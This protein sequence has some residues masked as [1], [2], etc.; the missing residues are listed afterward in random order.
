M[1]IAVNTRALLPGKMEGYGYYI[2]EVF[3]RIAQLH[4]EHEFYFFFD[5][6]FA[7]QFVYAQN[8]KPVVI[9]PQ[10]RLPF[11]WKIWYNLQVPAVLKKINADVFVSPD[12]F[13]S[14]RTN[15]PQCL[16]VHD[17]AFLH[18]PAFLLNKHLRYYNKY[19]AKFL[20]KAKVVVTVSEFSKQDICNQYK[21]EQDKVHVTYNATNPVFQPMEY[22]EKE[23]IKQQYTDGCEYFIF[24]GTIH[25]RK[26]LINLLRAFSVFKKKQSSNM[27]L[28][29]TGRMTWKTEEF[30]KLLNTFK[31]RN[32]VRLTGYISKK[33]L[34]GLVGSA[35]AMVYPS[36]FEGFGVPP[37]EALQ[38]HVPA[39]VSRNSAMPEVGADAYL[40]VNPESFED[41]AQK[42]MLLYK[43][44]TLRNK[45][46]ENGQQRLALFSW[47]KTAKKM[48]DCIE[49][50]AHT[51]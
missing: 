49:L 41:I 5:R 28:V 50:A 51:E 17:L 32:D 43:D 25:P 3:S 26:N 34:A 19:T 33:E 16:V 37:L 39:I 11:L 22:E 48:W 42:M 29:I 30:T 4:P 38:C 23:K 21:I 35:Y 8:I 10:A 9:K 7:S 2:E 20:A 47:D 40:Y 31:F 14:L 6:P 12:G 45:L 24:T 44:E 13:C 15:V 27:K 46:V 18:Y 1:V 36:F